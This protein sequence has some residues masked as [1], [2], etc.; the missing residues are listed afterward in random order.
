MKSLARAVGYW[1]LPADIPKA[2]ERRSGPDGHST[3]KRERFDGTNGPFYFA[4]YS[5][6]R[7]NEKR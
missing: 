6:G 2:A 7:T 3:P 5:A 4:E 1:G